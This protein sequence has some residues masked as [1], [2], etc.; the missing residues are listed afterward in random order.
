MNLFKNLWGQPVTPKSESS[1]RDIYKNLYPESVRYALQYREAKLGK[2]EMF[3]LLD[4]FVFEDVYLVVKAYADI[5]EQQAKFLQDL[6][7]LF[8]KPDWEKD[9]LRD[10]LRDHITQLPDGIMVTGTKLAQLNRYGSDHWQTVFGNLAE[11]TFAANEEDVPCLIAHTPLIA[12]HHFV[13]VYSHERSVG[14]ILILVPAWMEDKDNDMMG[15]QVV[16]NPIP[17]VNI[18]E[19]SECLSGQWSCFKHECPLHNLYC[20]SVVFIDDTINTGNTA[21]KLQSFWHTEYGLN[22]PIEQVRV[23]TDLRGR[24]YPKAKPKAE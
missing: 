9:A 13:R 6:A 15:Y 8:V 14:K 1:I 19:K 3:D 10:L 2:P 4:R 23:I 20:R 21:G 7:R 5:P 17:S 11:K 16:F 22:I 12:F 24:G 18:Q